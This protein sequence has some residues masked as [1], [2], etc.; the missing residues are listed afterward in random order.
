MKRSAVLGEVVKLVED[1]MNTLW[2]ASKK[3]PDQSNL[4]AEYA[5]AARTLGSLHG[6]LIY[7]LKEAE[8]IEA[9]ERLAQGNER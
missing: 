3:E 2:D 6:D 8:E 9:V 4:K 1:R 5:Q 7:K